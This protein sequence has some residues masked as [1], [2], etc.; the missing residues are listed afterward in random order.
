MTHLKDDCPFYPKDN[1]TLFD[2]QRLYKEYRGQ[3][4]DC[5]NKWNMIAQDGYTFLKEIVDNK[6]N[7]FYDYIHPK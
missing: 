3:C 6:K 7:K 5:D 1:P 4:R 2:T